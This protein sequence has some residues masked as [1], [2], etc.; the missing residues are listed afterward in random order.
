MQWSA[1]VFAVESQMSHQHK[2]EDVE[3]NSQTSATTPETIA[4]GEDLEAAYLPTLLESAHCPTTSSLKQLASVSS[5]HGGDQITQLIGRQEPINF[6]VTSVEAT[7][8]FRQWV[9]RATDIV[10]TTYPKTGTTWVQQICEMLRCDA[11]G[12][13]ESEAMSFEAIEQVQPLVEYA[14][15]VGQCLD[16]EQRGGLH[17]RMFKSHASL[18]RSPARFCGDVDGQADCKYLVTIRDPAAALVS[19]FNFQ[20][21]K[22]ENSE[23]VFFLG[24]GSDKCQSADEMLDRCGWPLISGNTLWETYLEFW[25]CRHQPNVMLLAYE[26]MLSRTD[27]AVKRIAAF[28]GI[29]ADEARV[30]RVLARSTKEFMGGEHASKFDESW[31]RKQQIQYGRTPVLINPASRVTAGAKSNTLKSET[32]ERINKQWQLDITSATGLKTYGDMLA[33]WRQEVDFELSG[34]CMQCSSCFRAHGVSA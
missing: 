34:N 27:V 21:Q 22:G 28:M 12:M 24:N 20:D 25:R 3:E 15:D 33:Q 8:R 11:A 14:Y 17:P 16:D 10:V 4:G 2:T 7:R 9:P 23:T 30:A 32:V 13:D 5:L 19:W 18:S 31:V 1:A 6:G 29:H 26:D